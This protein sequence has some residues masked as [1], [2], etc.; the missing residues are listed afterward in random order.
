[1]S[2]RWIA[3][4]GC[5]SKDSQREE[6]LNH[7]LFRK[8]PR[9]RQSTFEALDHPALRPLPEQPY[10][11]AGWKKALVHIEYHVEV[12]G[13]YYSVPYQLVKNHLEVSLTAHRRVFPRQP[14][15]GQPPAISEKGAG[16]ARRSSICPRAIGHA[17]WTPQRLI[18]WAK[19]TGPNTA[20]ATG[21]SGAS[22]R[23]MST[24]PTWEFCAWVNPR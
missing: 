23:L 6:Q 22:I 16:T 2:W 12:D 3:T 20:G 15:G 14:A 13:H 18:R 24:G 19:Q 8:L 9:S 17:E 7:R 1:M 11:Y 10:V 5:R 21:L 4:A